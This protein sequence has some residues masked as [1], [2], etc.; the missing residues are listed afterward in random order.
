MRTHLLISLKRAVC[1]F[2]FRI[3]NRTVKI[4]FMSAV[5]KDSILNE[6]VTLYEEVILRTVIIGRYSYVASNTIINNTTIGSFC[7]IGANCKIGIGKHPSSVFVSTHPIFFS[8]LKQC[9][10]AF[11]DTSFYEETV[12]VEIGSDVWIGAN[13]IICDGVK[14]GH[15]AIVGAGA[16]V[17]KDIPAY[18]IVGG[19]P[20]KIIRYRFTVDDIAFL[21]ALKWWEKDIGFM[22]ANFKKFHDISKL[23]EWL[24][25]KETDYNLFGS[26]C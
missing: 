14:I 9:Q 3:Q 18:A 20:A 26:N 10:V 22:Q 13:A 1:A 15:G 21:L 12:P 24:V 7:S 23:K 11:T 25:N 17:T 8:P 16:V 4:G 19:V 6:F 5:S 2:L